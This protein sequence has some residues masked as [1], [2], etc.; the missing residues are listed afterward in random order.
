MQL[1][2]RNTSQKALVDCTAG[3]TQTVTKPNDFVSHLDYFVKAE[4]NTPDMHHFFIK[5]K[6]QNLKILILVLSTILM[7]AISSTLAMHVANKNEKVD[8][9]SIEDKSQALDDSKTPNEVAQKTIQLQNLT[10]ENQRLDAI[11]AEKQ[12]IYNKLLAL[13]TTPNSQEQ[14]ELLKR[15]QEL[16]QILIS[17]YPELSD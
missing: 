5:N 17:E 2:I 1:F 16:N 4:H 10:Q 6:C 3:I 11:L 13:Q 14:Y 9:I 8:T 7:I 15:N 12:E